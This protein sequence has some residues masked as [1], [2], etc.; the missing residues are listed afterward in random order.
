MNYELCS[1]NFIIFIVTDADTWKKLNAVLPQTVATCWPII[2]LEVP[3]ERKKPK[4]PDY[5]SKKKCFTFA[6]KQ[7]WM[8][9]DPGILESTAL[10]Y[11]TK[12][13]AKKYPHIPQQVLHNVS[14]QVPL[15]AKAIENELCKLEMFYDDSNNISNKEA[16]LNKSRDAD[17][18]YFAIMQ[19]VMSGNLEHVFKLITTDKDIDKH[20]F[21]LSVFFEREFKS[22]WQIKTQ[23]STGSSYKQRTASML[24]FEDL[25]QAMGCLVEAEWRLKQGLATG[26]QCF[27]YMLITL[28]KI[29]AKSKY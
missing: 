15:E 23:A 17:I 3:Y 14:V 11:I 28:C 10:E 6:E 26:L 4:I 13:A 2:L 25:A 27:D 1:L 24:S 8:F 22:L 12:L 7:G 19:Q 16:I 29:F 20:F 9:S 21:I 18:N 5:I